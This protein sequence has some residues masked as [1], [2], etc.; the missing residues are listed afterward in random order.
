GEV[1]QFVNQT[2]CNFVAVVGAAG[3]PQ[4]FASQ[5]AIGEVVQFAGVC[6]SVGVVLKE[7]V[8]GGLAL[9]Q[10]EKASSID[11]AHHAVRVHAIEGLR[12][13]I[14][15]G[16]I[17]ERGDSEPHL[18]IPGVG[19]LGAISPGAALNLSTHDNFGRGDDVVAGAA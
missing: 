13:A 3:I 10:V 12:G 15:V 2:G 8:E 14:N 9:P 19:K 6:D 1:D 16:D 17:G 5:A 11:G 4:S 18:Q 7:A